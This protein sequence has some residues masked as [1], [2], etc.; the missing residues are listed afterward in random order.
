[1]LIMLALIYLSGEWK[2]WCWFPKTNFSYLAS[3]KSDVNL[4]FTFEC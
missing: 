3:V 4:Y 2:I 1:M